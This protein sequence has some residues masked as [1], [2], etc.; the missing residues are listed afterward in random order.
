MFYIMLAI[1]LSNSISFINY[2]SIV[3]DL[4]IKL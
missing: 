2:Y 3:I 1:G 4:L